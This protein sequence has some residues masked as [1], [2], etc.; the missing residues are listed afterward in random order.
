MRV[1]KEEYSG[2][3][4]D[5][6]LFHGWGANAEDLF[7]LGKLLSRANIRRAFFPDGLFSVPGVPMGR[8]WFTIDPNELQAAMLQGKFRDFASQKPKELQESIQESLNFIK[9]E[10]IDPANCIIGGFSQGSMLALH[11]SFAL[12]APPAFLVLLSS[13]YL[14]AET[15]LEEAPKKCIRFFQSH[16]TY[17]PVLP[18]DGAKLLYEKLK[19][20]SWPGDFVEFMGQHEIPMEVLEKLQAAL[21]AA[22]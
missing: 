19:A 11:L 18:V 6:I 20:S 7:P 12:E 16:G 9:E 21:L 14:D 8:A 4:K 22:P 13:A 3:E 1:L 15:I 5:L 17:D 2:G 10:D